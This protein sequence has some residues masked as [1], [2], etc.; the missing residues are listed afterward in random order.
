MGNINKDQYQLEQDK[1]L[2]TM[3]D[4]RFFNPWKY[5]TTHFLDDRSL[6]L[7]S[8]LELY[9]TS[10]CNQKCEYCYLQKHPELYPKEVNKPELIL[11]NL[12]LLL[13]YLMINNYHIPEV[14]IFSG[15][16][17]Q[18]Q[19]GWDILD[20]ILKYLEKGV[21]IDC[22]T[23]PSNCSFV[24]SE[25]AL[26]KM[27]QYI[28]KYKL[29]DCYL[30]ISVSVDGKIVDE[31]GRPRNDKENKYT[32]EFYDRV[33]AFARVNDFLFHPMVSSQNVKYWKENYQWWM[34][35]LKK[36][37]YSS[38]SIM[39]LEVRD[40][41]WTDESIKDYCEFLKMLMN[42][43]MVEKCNNDP[44][45]FADYISN[46]HL[47]REFNESNGYFPW[48]IGTGK[49][50]LGCTITD[51]LTVRLGDL[52]ICPCH[53]TAYNQY[54]YGYFTV[55]DDEISGV[56]AVNPILAT[57]IWMGNNLTTTPI[58]D[59][60]PIN[61]CCLHGC[62]GAQTEYGKDPFMPLENVCKFF[63]AK[64]STIFKYYREHGI[65]DCLKAYGPN[66][67]FSDLVGTILL[68]NDR[69]GDNLDE[70]GAV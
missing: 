58:C 54:L 20:M 37:N 12:E 46:A 59:A 60:C 44:Q 21:L 61:E 8:N 70:L 39:M 49:S 43:W 1:L 51:H 3:L 69:L 47:K 9:I 22:I 13:K 63:K 29:F 35:F 68:I 14:S 7:D 26:Q 19:F 27:Q 24:N 15:D 10:T 5:I 50:F 66:K 42:N 62:L 16:I 30:G 28:D 45:E 25:I 18:S 33:G 2:Q 55:E 32:D 34:E 57:K 38:D 17:W 11:H 41:N 4:Y 52:A 6:R 53:R 67:I 23:L 31:A 48:F 64:Y 36:Y 40:G 65:I 56:K